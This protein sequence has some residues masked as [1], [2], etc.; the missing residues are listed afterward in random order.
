MSMI[1]QLKL[2]EQNELLALLEE[3]D[4]NWFSMDVVY[5]APHVERVWRQHGNIR[6]FLHRI[7]PCERD[8]AL[9]HPHDWPSAMHILDGVYEMDV[10]EGMSISS[11]LEL[12]AGSY[13]EMV[14][15]WGKHSVRPIKLVH[16]LMIAGPKHPKD[17]LIPFDK[18][19][20][21][22]EPLAPDV[23]SDVLSFFRSDYAL[24]MYG[25]YKEV[26]Y[27][28]PT[29]KKFIGQKPGS[30]ERSPM[31]KPGDSNDE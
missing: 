28:L 22:Q 21:K 19:K 31:R 20:K 27:T 11:T 24:S 5:H 23:K 1:E 30:R 3:P 26:Q 12:H 29:R 16:A 18:P 14:Q 13:Y 2:F 25:A 6:V 10:G 7:H 4:D 8:E 9:W 17:T 15:P